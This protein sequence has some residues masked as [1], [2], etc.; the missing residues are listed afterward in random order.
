MK[1]FIV[2]LNLKCP[3]QPH[4]PMNIFNKKLLRLLGPDRVCLNLNIELRHLRK[5]YGHC[6]LFIRVN[7][8]EIYRWRIG[9]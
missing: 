8:M 6:R 3:V 4:L 5:E 2:M 9:C 7:E 1:E